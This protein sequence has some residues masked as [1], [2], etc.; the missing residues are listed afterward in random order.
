MCETYA[1]T[2]DLRKQKSQSYTPCQSDVSAVERRPL[3]DK[4]INALEGGK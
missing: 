1:M 2:I 3:K 4:V